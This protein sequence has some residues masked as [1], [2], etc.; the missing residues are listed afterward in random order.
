VCVAEFRFAGVIGDVVALDTKGMAGVPQKKK[1]EIKQAIVDA[2]YKLFAKRGYAATNITDIARAAGVAPANV[3]VYFRS[4][5]EIL[6]TI[7][8]PWLVRQIDDLEG[9]LARLRDPRRRLRKILT[10]IWRDIPSADNGFAHTMMQAIATTT[11]REGYSPNLRLTVENRVAKLL[12]SCLP[13]PDHMSSRELANILLMA[14][15]GYALN[16][17][18]KGGAVCP[19]DQLKLFSTILLGGA[20]M[21]TKRPMGKPGKGPVK[22]GASDGNARMAG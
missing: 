19:D 4:K 12:D 17:H 16:F 3:Y 10:T 13:R 11:A 20:D 15:D 6:F 22:R 21:S 5:L 9:A 2:A 14:F 18:L 1:A 7:Y 8:E